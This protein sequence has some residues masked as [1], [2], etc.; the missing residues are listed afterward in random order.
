MKKIAFRREDLANASPFIEEDFGFPHTMPTTPAELAANEEAD[1]KGAEM[2]GRL[3]VFGMALM[4]LIA[5][6]VHFWFRQ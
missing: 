6:G 5:L 1:K 4:A 2:L 3:I